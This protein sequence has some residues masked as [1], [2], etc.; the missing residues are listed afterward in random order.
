MVMLL[1]LSLVSGLYLICFLWFW[2]L[3]NNAIHTARQNAVLHE[4]VS[5]LIPFERGLELRQKERRIV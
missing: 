4:P 3:C 1:I 2:S 5:N